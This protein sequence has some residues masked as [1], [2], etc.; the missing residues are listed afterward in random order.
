V[1]ET[2]V[3]LG[4]AHDYL[5]K[6][7]THPGIKKRIEHTL[8][9]VAGRTVQVRY[10]VIQPRPELV[11]CLDTYEARMG[12]GSLF[13]FHQQ[14]AGRVASQPAVSP[15]AVLGRHAGSGRSA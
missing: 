10:E 14:S 13:S 4:F 2:E 6:P 3:V 15:V 11:C 5:A 1:S 7:L 9:A 8:S 12:L